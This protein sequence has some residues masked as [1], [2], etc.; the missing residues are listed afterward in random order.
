[1]SGD[2]YSV[3]NFP[4]CLVHDIFD[5]IEALGVHK[6]TTANDANYSAALVAYSVQSVFGGS[7]EFDDCLPYPDAQSIGD[8]QFKAWEIDAIRRVWGAADNFNMSLMSAVTH[9]VRPL[10]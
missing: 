5:D 4:L 10:L 6:R 2:L 7:V 9:I 1:M 8:G 3:D